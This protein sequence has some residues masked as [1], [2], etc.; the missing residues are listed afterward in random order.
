MVSM[1]FL[2][3]T[4]CGSH[5]VHGNGNIKTVSRSV[6]EFNKVAIGGKY[7]VEIHV[8]KQQSLTLKTDSNI[9]PLVSTRVKDGVLKIENLKGYTFSSSQPVIININVQ[10]LD[11]IASAGYNMVLVDG[12]NNN[13]FVLTIGGAG[14]A[15]LT[16]K[17][18]EFI[19][20]AA[21]SSNIN[22]NKLVAKD[23]KVEMIGAVDVK[24]H[25]TNSLSYKII[26]SGDLKYSGSPKITSSTIR[27]VGNVT[28]IKK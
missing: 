14:E 5:H 7:H 9:D 24:V 12:I 3:L 28:P 1:L 27:G 20:K 22:A 19:I 23:V 13:R 16:G 21:G 18:N 8:G 6:P 25:A 10:S 17:T 26:G 4:G 2:L 11:Q 15:D